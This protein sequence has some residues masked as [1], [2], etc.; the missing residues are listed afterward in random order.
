MQVDSNQLWRPDGT[1][2]W[3]LCLGTIDWWCLFCCNS[4]AESSACP[5]PGKKPEGRKRLG[6]IKLDVADVVENRRLSDTWALMDSQQG[7]IQL[8]LEWMPLEL[9]TV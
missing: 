8:K 6:F 2:A 4:I 5:C 7:E 3:Q 9:A 1:Y